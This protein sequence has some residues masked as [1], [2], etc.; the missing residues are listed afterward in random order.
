[1]WPIHPLRIFIQIYFTTSHTPFIPFL[2]LCF[3][4]RSSF[5]FVHSTF[6]I[7]LIYFSAPLFFAFLLSF[8]PLIFITVCLYP[9]IH[10]SYCQ[11]QWLS[12]LRPLTCRDCGFESHRKHGCECCVLSGRGLCDGLITHPEEST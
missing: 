3:H 5:I 12:G 10:Y 6:F 8:F 11:S 2:F 7:F 4:S 9:Y 1:M